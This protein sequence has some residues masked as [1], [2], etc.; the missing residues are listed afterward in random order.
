MLHTFWIIESVK[1][2]YS[3]LGGDGEDT[4]AMVMTGEVFGGAALMRG[5][6]R[7]PTKVGAAPQHSM[8]PA[9]GS[10]DARRAMAVAPG[11][12]D[13]AGNTKYAAQPV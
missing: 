11:T 1:Q 5:L 8:R 2:T 9:K 10:D 4:P 6:P 7:R 13:R 12:G 3:R